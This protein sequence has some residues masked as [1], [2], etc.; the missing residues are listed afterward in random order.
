MF[1]SSSSGP[2]GASRFLLAGDV[3]E[4]IDPRLLAAGLPRLD[5]LKI[6]HHGSRTATT[7][8]FVE[9][10]RPRIAIASAG[11]GNPYGHPTRQTLDRLRAAGATVYRTDQDGSVRVDL[12]G[13]RDRG[14]YAKA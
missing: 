2:S 4:A 3:E 12:H 13:S 5:L 10:V 7:Q 8:A 14:Q 1:R 6:A 9:A 11:A